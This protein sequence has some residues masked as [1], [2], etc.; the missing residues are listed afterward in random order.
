MDTVGFGDQ[1]N[2]EDSSKSIVDHIDKQFE[3]YLHEELKVERCLS[4]Y[5][6]TRIHVCLYFISPT[7]HGLV[8]IKYSVFVLFLSRKFFLWNLKQLMFIF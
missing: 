6:D 2:K 4:L 8:I 3:A 7:G 5:Q 1:V